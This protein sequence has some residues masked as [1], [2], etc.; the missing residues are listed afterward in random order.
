ML[1]LI[2]MYAVSDE[3]RSM[4]ASRLDDVARK[5]EAFRR[6]FTASGELLNGAG[7]ELPDETT[8]SR[9]G[10]ART[11]GPLIAAGE[12]VTAYYVVDCATRERA[13]ALAE[14]LLDDHVIAVEVRGIHDWF[15]MV[16]RGGVPVTGPSDA[17]TDRR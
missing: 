13:I 2:L 14:R 7:L 12:H 5:H 16:K 15:G 11:T 6:E 1:S 8:A 4:S 3:T 17:G 9:L 10:R